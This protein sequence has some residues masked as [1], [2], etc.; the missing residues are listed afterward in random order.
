VG[1]FLTICKPVSFSRKTVLRG[2]SKKESAV[3]VAEDRQSEKAQK[4][5]E[6]E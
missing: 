6:E 3:L 2:V 1:N 5:E 4:V